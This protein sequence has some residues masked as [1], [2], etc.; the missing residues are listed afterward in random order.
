M[1]KTVLRI[2]IPTT[3][4]DPDFF[5]NPDPVHF[6][7]EKIKKIYIQNCNIQYLFLGL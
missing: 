4:P 2:H 5:M 3:V 1:F 7:V 6:T